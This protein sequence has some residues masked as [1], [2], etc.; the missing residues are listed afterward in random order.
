MVTTEQEAILLRGI[1]FKNLALK[2]IDGEKSNAQRKLNA[3]LIDNKSTIAKLEAF[4]EKY[5]LGFRLEYL[6]KVFY[7]PDELSAFLKTKSLKFQVK[8]FFAI[9]WQ[10]IKK[11]FFKTK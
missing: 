9:T 7:T 8:A 4:E 3:F 5:L 10:L 2:G 11:R 6:K 1:K